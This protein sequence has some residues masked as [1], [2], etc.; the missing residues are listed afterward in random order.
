MTFTR[1]AEAAEGGTEIATVNG[2]H[3]RGE[4]RRHHGGYQHRYPDVREKP[5]YWDNG[6]H[7]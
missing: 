5:G 4:H 2:D 6:R 7:G 3:D 1:G